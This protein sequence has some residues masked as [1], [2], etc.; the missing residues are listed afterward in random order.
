M[1]TNWSKQYI[2]LGPKNKSIE[3]LGQKKEREVWLYQKG[4]KNADDGSLSLKKSFL[5]KSINLTGLITMA[6]NLVP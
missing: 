6:M 4:E 3:Q 5:S 1:S 2:N